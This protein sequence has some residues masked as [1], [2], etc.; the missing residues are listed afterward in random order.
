MAGR[1]DGERQRQPA[2]ESLSWKSARLQSARSLPRELARKQDRTEDLVRPVGRHRLLCRTSRRG[3][4]QRQ[5]I[6]RLGWLFS[7][8]PHPESERRRIVSAALHYGR[9]LLRR[10]RIGLEYTLDA[11][12]AA[13]LMQPPDSHGNRAAVFSHRRGSVAPISLAPSRAR[14][15]AGFRRPLEVVT[16]FCEPQ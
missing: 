5:R 16:V 2:A 4:G 3:S 10:P 14:K 6:R 8:I 9:L 11:V 7:A 1:A 13:V 12:L 15:Q